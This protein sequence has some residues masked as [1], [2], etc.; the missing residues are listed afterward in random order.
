MA[1][2]DSK[3]VLNIDTSEAQL[4]IANLKKMVSEY[5]KEL[6][7]CIVGSDEAAAAADRLN[8]AQTALSA[9]QKGA[10]DTM[11]QLDNSYNGLTAQMRKLK[12][13]Q[14][15]IDTSTEAGAKAF[16]EYAAK[17][18]AIQ[19]KLT[20]MDAKNGVYSRNVGN[21]TKSMTDAFNNVGLS[22][23]NI[24]PL[25]QQLGDS[26]VKS[27]A[28]GGTAMKGLSAGLKGVG[29]SML[30]LAANPVGA[31]IMAIVVAVKAAVA[32]FNK[33]KESV[34]GNEVASNN[35]AKAL[36][37]IKGIINGIKLVF[38]NLVES[39]TAGMAV[40]G[41]AISGIMEFLGIA[42]EMTKAENEIADLQASNAEQHRQNIIENSKLELEASEARAKAADKE[43][44]TAEERLAYAKEYA[45]KQKEI[46]AN[47][48]EEAQNEL[49]LLE[50]QAATGKNNKEMND[51]LAEAQAKVNNVQK[52]YNDTLRSTNKELNNLNNE[53]AK[54]TE[55]KQ[56]KAAEAW[57]KHVEEVKEAKKAYQEVEDVLRNYSNS[58]MQNDIDAVN[59][60]WD[61]AAK[62]ATDAATK[63]GKTQK[64]LKATLDEIAENR[65]TDLTNIYQKYGKMFEDA[66]NKFYA[67]YQTDKQ[68]KI[69]AERAKLEAE[70]ETYR[71]VMKLQVQV[72][73][74]TQE[75]MDANLKE[76]DTYIQKT[77]D[78]LTKDLDNADLKQEI[79]DI[80]TPPED[81]AETF[82]KNITD[83]LEKG[84]ITPEV[85]RKALEKLGFTAEDINK[86]LKDVADGIE[87]DNMTA[88]LVGALDEMSQFAAEISSIG[89]G[90]SS[91][92]G[93]VF[94]DLSEGL[95]D[96][97]KNLKTGGK[98][99]Q[100]YGK[101]AELAFQVA[102]DALGALADEQDTS[103]KEGFEKHKKLQ[104]AQATMTM[105]AGIVA[106]MVNSIRD[107]GVPA[108]PI[109]GSVLSTMIATM[110]GVQIDKIRKTQFDGDSSGD[111]SAS[112]NLSSIA[113]VANPTTY[114]QEVNSANIEEGITN[115]RVYVLQSDIEATGKKVKVAQTE[116]RF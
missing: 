37:P 2:I 28:Q 93:K 6:D 100:A 29:K 112:V 70:K 8:K 81:F 91:E 38:D 55:D 13:E 99:W 77:I 26:M 113:G 31:V 50:A 12:D 106:A 41:S 35:M 22:L 72:G 102:G 71:E 62:K 74:M 33:F 7:N 96:I 107:L 52:Q 64:E 16:D 115:Q 109:V 67:L 45:E 23:G 21:Y 86:I 53:V 4:S 42:P 9:A 83:K 11:G 87:W 65:S 105:L 78:T 14:K 49:K 79:A 27:S 98:S 40:I 90:I 82:K 20:E 10:I 32:I 76:Y 88:G 54:E 36:A 68:N 73:A 57:K 111:A 56:K 92:W 18:Y 94:S 3:K 51:K 85:A 25:F 97:S 5:R 1:E 63:A 114:T 17:I 15:N 95:T 108:G 104:I 110:G 66:N 69:D 59:K 48:L 103:S 116:S 58:E 46:A 84:E 34:E 47:N 75:E 30:S 101:M 19:D 61:D 60:K 89:D 43:H 80:L 24:S 39:I 44:Y